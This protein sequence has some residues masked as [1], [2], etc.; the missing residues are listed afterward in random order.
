[1][2]WVYQLQ[3]GSKEQQKPW[4]H[5]QSFPQGSGKLPGEHGVSPAG[6]PLVPQL[7]DSR[8]HLALGFVPQ[9]HVTHWAKALKD[10]LFLGLDCNR[11]W[12]I[13]VNAFLSQ[14]VAF[15]DHCTVILENY[16][17]ER[18][19]NSVGIRPLGELFYTR[20]KVCFYVFLF[21]YAYS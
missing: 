8:K 15:P 3:I 10:I 6:V 20:P 17:K 19:E 18:V 9:E 4:V 5:Y 21:L 11:A 7:R 1:M 12:A 14:D 2:K 13:L 16:K